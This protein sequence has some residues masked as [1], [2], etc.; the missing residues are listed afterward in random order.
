MLSV[1]I[2][3]SAQQAYYPHYY[4][5]QNPTQPPS[6]NYAQG[7]PQAYPPNQYQQPY[8]QRPVQPQAQAFTPPTTVKPQNP[9][10][11]APIEPLED[12][13]KT[14]NELSIKAQHAMQR[15]DYAEAYCMLRPLANRGNTESEYTLG[16]MYFNGYG[17]SV[18]EAR[19][20]LW[21]TK[22]ADQGHAE[23]SF[24][25][26]MAYLAGEGV[27]KDE[28]T[29]L[30]WLLRAAKHGQEDAAYIIRSRV[31]LGSKAAKAFVKELIRTNSSILN[32]RLWVRVGKANVRSGP[33]KGH[34]LLVTLKKNDPLIELNRRGKWLQIGIPGTETLGWIYN[35]LVTKKAP[36][37][38]Q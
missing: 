20:I 2:P 4:P 31:A 27:D 21:W 35:S 10:P 15:G 33:A 28:G 5:A 23:A 29:A 12:N 18:D 11:A 3:A 38:S 37:T 1:L 34:K 16:W 9:A 8:Q 26:A 14:T 6:Q 25:I 30:E 13:K 7:Y 36:E 22:A 17:L 24:A 32:E 19:A